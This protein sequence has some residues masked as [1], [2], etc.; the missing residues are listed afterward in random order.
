M[1]RDALHAHVWTC[2][3]GLRVN[4]S[5][6]SSSTS[7]FGFDTRQLTGLESQLR[8]LMHC[9]FSVKCHCQPEHVFCLA[10]TICVHIWLC[11]D[12][13][14]GWLPLLLLFF[15]KWWP[16][17]SGNSGHYHPGAGTVCFGTF[18]PKQT[19]ALLFFFIHSGVSL[20]HKS[21]I[22]QALWVSPGFFAFLTKRAGYK[23][24]T[25]WWKIPRSKTTQ[26]GLGIY[27]RGRA[28]A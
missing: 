11:P 1:C 28:L 4:F 9:S 12:V 10:W 16:S 23:I 5:C 15:K 6:R 14:A 8:P 19:F 13:N 20:S 22:T 7:H 21:Q 2:T 17:S 24:C 3:W 18:W 27:L 25:P 26:R